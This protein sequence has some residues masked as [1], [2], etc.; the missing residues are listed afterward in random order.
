MQIRKTNDS[1]LNS[2]WSVKNEDLL[3]LL[4][5]GTPI[6]RSHP[7]AN[8]VGAERSPAVMPEWPERQKR[9]SFSDIKC[10]LFGMRILVGRRGSEDWFS[11]QW[12]KQLIFWTF[13]MFDG[14]LTRCFTQPP[15]QQSIINNSFE[16]TGVLL[17]HTSAWSP[18][19]LLSPNL[20]VSP[21]PCLKVDLNPSP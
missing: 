19:P 13:R 15:K 2:N 6:A 9:W 4:A 11:Y 3:C 14:F 21:F 1:A 12:D 16:S 5:D 8:Y 10:H 20:V 7:P 18:S 17:P